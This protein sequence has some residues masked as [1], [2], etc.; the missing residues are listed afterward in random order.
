MMLLTKP[1]AVVK[2]FKS[3]TFHQLQVFE[4]AARHGNFTRAAE[5]LLLTQPTVSIQIKQLSKVI[6]FPLFKQIGK[7]IYLTEAGQELLTIARE[8]F[9]KFEKLELKIADLKDFKSAQLNLGVVTTAKYVISH[10]LQAFCQKYPNV[11]ISLTVASQEELFER[12]M[13]D[14]D[15]LYL[16]RQPLEKISIPH[17]P[18]VENPL[19]AIARQDH[20]LTG[21]K[22]ITLEQLARESLILPEPSSPM[23]E[24]VERL[25]VKYKIPLQVKLELGNNEAIKEAIALGLGISIVSLHAIGLNELKTSFTLLDVKHFPIIQ[26]WAI[27][28][29]P[30]PSLSTIA[31][32]FFEFLQA[33][34]KQVIEK[35]SLAKLSIM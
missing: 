9:Q 22:Q 26:H 34:G 1:R 6:G 31:H 5:E 24:A 20:R 8:T 19:V 11:N 17:Y 29:S 7:N 10:I 13:S 14:R 27:A 4:A 32:T 30:S 25:F 3:I 2:Q 28:Y 18:F 16:L 23:R 12:M 21:K 33:E 15:D 35:T